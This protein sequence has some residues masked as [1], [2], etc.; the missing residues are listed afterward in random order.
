[1]QN[2]A[3]GSWQHSPRLILITTTLDIQWVIDNVIDLKAMM[4]DNSF[5]SIDIPDFSYQKHQPN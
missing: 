1:M 2:I 5:D 4:P 3:T